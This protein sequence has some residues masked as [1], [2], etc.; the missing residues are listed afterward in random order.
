MEDVAVAL[1][2]A[3]GDMHAEPPAGVLE[4]LAR[5]AGD[6]LGVRHRL[7]DA[8]EHVAGN[9]ALGQHEQRR[10]G[11]GCLLQATHTD[12]E[13]VLLL[14]ELRLDLGHCDAHRHSSSSHETLT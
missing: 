12:F 13:V 9:R 14:A 4:R 1:E 10:T 11:S 3:A 5:R 2:Q 7:V 6:L 8:P